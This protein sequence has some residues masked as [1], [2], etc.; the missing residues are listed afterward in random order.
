[1]MRRRALITVT[2][3]VAALACTTPASAQEVG[4]SAE[5]AQA[6]QL[7]AAATADV[8]T[9]EGTTT[10]GAQPGRRERNLRKRGP[11]HSHLNDVGQSA[12]SIDDATFLDPF[13]AHPPLDYDYTDALPVPGTAHHGLDEGYDL[14]R[15]H[16]FDEEDAG[17]DDRSLL[18]TAAAPSLRDGLTNSGSK[19]GGHYRDDLNNDI[20]RLY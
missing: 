17:A 12:P 1:M 11:Q 6:Q 8:P 16:P 20:T 4:V 9:D 7:A 5:R 3:T 18:L 15:T 14:L 19:H 10:D 2:A 13:S